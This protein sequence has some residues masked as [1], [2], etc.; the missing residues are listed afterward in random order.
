MV[1]MT[2]MMVKMML[3]TTMM[4]TK[5]YDNDLA[6]IDDIPSHDMHCQALNQYYGNDYLLGQL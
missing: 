6:P 5:E 3:M 1:V 4:N 2:V